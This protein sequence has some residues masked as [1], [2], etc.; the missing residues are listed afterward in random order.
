MD[1]GDVCIVRSRY[2]SLASYAT[3]PDDL[4]YMGAR[5]AAYDAAPS[6]E[7]GNAAL[8]GNGRT[9]EALDKIRLYRLRGM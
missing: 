8:S 2:H 7:T 1:L 5:A 6:I 3:T 9:M 4:L